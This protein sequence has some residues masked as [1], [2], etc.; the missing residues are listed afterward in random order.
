MLRRE[1][2]DKVSLAYRIVGIAALLIGCILEITAIVCG[3]VN[4]FSVL[5][6]IF[7]AAVAAYVLLDDEL[8]KRLKENKVMKFI[9]SALTE[10]LIIGCIVAAALGMMMCVY[11]GSFLPEQPNTVIVMGCQVMGEQPSVMLQRRIDAAYAYLC[12]NE[13]AVC[14]A[15]GGVGDGADISEAEAIRRELVGKG[16]D[17]GRIY[18]DDKSTSTDENLANAA[19]IIKANE[20]DANVAIVTDGYHQMRSQKTAAKYGL[21]AA[22]VSCSTPWYVAEPM[23][24]R[25]M[26]ALIKCTIFGY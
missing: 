18:L 7:F 24:I 11:S 15:T 19:A 26:C 5:P 13:D 10:V 3:V 16:V 17:G 2:S 9:I 4:L 20:L 14:I 12:E 23:I 1:V 22:A 6:L 8:K 25:E 21:T